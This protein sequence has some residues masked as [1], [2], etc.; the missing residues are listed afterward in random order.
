MAGKEG[1]DDGDDRGHD[2]QA[3]Q[4]CFLVELLLAGERCLGPCFG[5]VVTDETANDHQR[6]HGEQPNDELHAHRLLI[7]RAAAEGVGQECDQCNA[8][9]AIGL[10]AVSGWA[11]RVTSVVASAVSN[12]AGVL[13]IILR[14]LEDDLHE[15]ATNVGDLGEDAAADAQHGCT[16]TLADGEADEACT[17]E[18]R[19]DE[20][21]DSDHEE[22]LNAD[23]EH[24]DRHAGLQWNSQGLQGVAAKTCK[25][26]A[27]VGAGVDSDTE[28][29]HAVATENAQDRAEQDDANGHDVARL[30]GSAFNGYCSVRGANR[31]QES[32]VD[33]HR[34]GDQEPQE[35][36]EFALLREV[37][38]AGLPDD[39]GN[40]AHG[41]MHRQRVHLDVLDDSEQGSDQR[42]HKTRIHERGAH[43]R[44]A[45]HAEDDL[46]VDGRQLQVSLACECNGR[47][48][49]RGERGGNDESGPVLGLGHFFVLRVCS[50]AERPSDE[51]GI[52]PNVRLDGGAVESLPTD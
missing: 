13:R 36:Q 8:G 42:D 31:I 14:K 34:T 15:I 28:P 38:L 37:T 45:E 2:D 51:V 52:V 7:R 47:D 32:E 3:S 43:D 4:R 48:R 21:H 18:F 29:S 49:Q 24:A 44:L 39:V 30:R 26:G 27:A 22:Q 19:R 33:D 6:T 23:Q 12:N 17:H 1:G 16:K 25:R 41:R 11:N 40:V 46:V 9:D 5:D 20:H 50:R 10:K 35:R